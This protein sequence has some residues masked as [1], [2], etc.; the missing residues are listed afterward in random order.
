MV[1]Q[2]GHVFSRWCQWG[3]CMQYVTDA[4]LVLC[5]A[6]AAAAG[7]Q[8]SRRCCQTLLLR[9]LFLQ[10]TVKTAVYAAAAAALVWLQVPCNGQGAASW[11]P[12]LE[13]RGGSHRAGAR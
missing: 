3:V 4:A 6:S 9:L 2:C 13:A 11:P 1:L 5:Q 7:N 12:R 10:V 8:V